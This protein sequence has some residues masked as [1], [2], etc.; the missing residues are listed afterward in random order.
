[1]TSA[2]LNRKQESSPQAPAKGN[3]TAALQVDSPAWLKATAEDLRR[4]FAGHAVYRHRVPLEPVKFFI[5][6]G[7]DRPAELTP[8]QEAAAAEE[9][10]RDGEEKRILDTD[11]LGRDE[12]LV[13]HAKALYVKVGAALAVLTHRPD[14]PPPYLCQFTSRQESQ[15]REAR[16]VLSNFVQRFGGGEYEQPELTTFLDLVNRAARGEALAIRDEVAA[17]LK[18]KAKEQGKTWGRSVFFEML[19]QFVPGRVNPEP[20]PEADSELM[21][22]I[23][24][25]CFSFVAEAKL[26][27]G[28]EYGAR[29]DEAHP[30]LWA[31]LDAW[32]REHGRG[33]A[34][35]SKWELA[36]MLCGQA[37]GQPAKDAEQ[38]RLFW[39]R[40]T[41][42]RAKAVPAGP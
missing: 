24:S 39:H 1:V 11:F 33:D 15:R 38:M 22:A 37:C 41:K 21:T 7:Y 20:F 18:R 28:A 36:G 26:H 9:L 29:I 35:P 32:L 14:F 10:Q 42:A 25:C 12:P 16:D 34:F 8:E 5:V 19:N 2:G 31:L 17:T 30:T 40:R 23:W 27:I 13:G 4:A 6:R 3:Q